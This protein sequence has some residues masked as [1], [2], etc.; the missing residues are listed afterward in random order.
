LY[1][2]DSFRET[3]VILLAMHHQAGANG[4]EVAEPAEPDLG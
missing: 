1:H 2:L 3:F 4:R